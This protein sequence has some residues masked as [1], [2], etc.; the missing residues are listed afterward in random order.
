MTRALFQSA[1]QAKEGGNDRREVML[2]KIP[3]NTRIKKGIDLKKK[4]I[5]FV[6]G[7]IFVLIVLYGIYNLKKVVP[8]NKEKIPVKVQTGD[9]PM[10]KK[11]SV[12]INTGGG[13]LNIRSDHSEKSQKIGQIPDK[14]KVEVQEEIDGWYKI[15]YNGKDGWISK[16]YTIIE[17]SAS[18]SQSADANTQQFQGSGY[19]FKYPKD[20]DV[21]NYSGLD[22]SAWIALSNNQLPTEA[23]K[24]SY[25]IPLEL[26][27]YSSD[28]KP[29]GGFRTDASAKKE[30]ASVGGV[31]GTKFTYVNSDTSTEIN[32]VEFERA[33]T[34]YEFYDNG[35][36]WEDLNK[37]LGTFV[38]Q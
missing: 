3:T 25:F 9:Q 24:G 15:S 14:T 20:W 23:P 2:S 32:V 26:K 34:L 11:L 1:G 29:T 31:S 30:P 38:F 6:L 7:L 12:I 37:V 19:T 22:G 28:K 33:G 35:G 13:P 8:G 21:Q 10:A 27:V 18:S 17:D 36:Y 5:L 16:K 4:K